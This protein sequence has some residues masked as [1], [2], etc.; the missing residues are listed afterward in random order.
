[1]TEIQG[2]TEHWWNECEC[3][4]DVD[5]KLSSVCIQCI[6]RTRF[7]GCENE[8]STICDRQRD[9]IERQIMEL[10]NCKKT[11]DLH[12]ESRTPLLES[13]ASQN[14]PTYTRI[15]VEPE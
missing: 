10:H 13:P 14:D 4:Y 1:M 9:E 7:K 8:F 3:I 15:V 2:C 5:G 11:D 6:Y 12:L